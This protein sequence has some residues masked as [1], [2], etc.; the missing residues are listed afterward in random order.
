MFTV[1]LVLLVLFLVTGYLSGALIKPFKELHG[2][3]HSLLYYGILSY[4]G[5]MITILL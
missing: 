3:Q 4:P 2:E 5:S 1:L